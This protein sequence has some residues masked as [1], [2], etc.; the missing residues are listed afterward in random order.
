MNLN[1]TL[2]NT[3]WPD[4]TNIS[5][6]EATLC[7]M[8]VTANRPY[9]KKT[10]YNSVNLIDTELTFNMVVAETDPNNHSEC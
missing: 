4:I 2:T 10:G 9:K 1:E 6:L 3:H 7:K 8:A 5:H